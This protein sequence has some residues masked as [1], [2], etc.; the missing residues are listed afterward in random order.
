MTAL[1]QRDAERQKRLKAREQS[2][3]LRDRRRLV[4]TS[5][6]N[7]RLY[8]KLFCLYQ[9]LKYHESAIPDYSALHGVDPGDLL[10]EEFMSDYLSGPEDEDIKSVM[11]WKLRM[12][13]ENRID[14]EKMDPSGC[15]PSGNLTHQENQENS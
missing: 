9:A 6:N 4:C 11:A 14:G 8:S 12:A 10:A 5:N 7:Q 3:K 2:T 15:I 13:R 1:A